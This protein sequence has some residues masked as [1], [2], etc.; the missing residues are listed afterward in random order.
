[1]THLFRTVGVCGVTL[2]TC[3]K[4][5]DGSLFSCVA[6]WWKLLWIF[7]AKNSCFSDVIGRVNLI[8]LFSMLQRAKVAINS[9]I[10]WIF[11]SYSLFRESF[12]EPIISFYFF[13]PSLTFNSHQFFK[14]SIPASL[15]CAL[16]WSDLLLKWRHSYKL[17]GTPGRIFPAWSQLIQVKS[18]RPSLLRCHSLTA[19]K[20]R[21]AIYLK[22]FSEGIWQIILG[23]PGREPVSLK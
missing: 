17:D 19:L 11:D 9:I 15:F 23:F 1:M 2:L 10:P 13:S 5:T 18:Q 4:L 20:A 6:Q 21:L 3:W 12:K 22:A 16:L 14:V 7:T 8:R